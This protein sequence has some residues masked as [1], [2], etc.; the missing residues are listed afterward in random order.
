MSAAPSVCRPV[1]LRRAVNDLAASV[2]F[3]REAF[4]L[5]YEVAR[6]TRPHNSSAL[7]FGKH[8]RDSFF[9]LWPLDD[10]DRRDRPGTSNFS[11]LVDDVDPVDA[12]ALAAGATEVVAPHD[13]E[14]MP[15][16]SGVKDPSGNWIRLAQS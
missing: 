5:T 13:V 15:R 8:G 7:M 14:G 4:G 10:P 9:L 16:S 6:R 2:A 11:L 1:Q 3:Y 12:R